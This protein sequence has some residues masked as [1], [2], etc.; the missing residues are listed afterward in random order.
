MAPAA[1]HPPPQH[2]GHGGDPEVA[3]LTPLLRHHQRLLI[4]SQAD[5]L[6]CTG[7]PHGAVAG[8]CGVGQGRSVRSMAPAVWGVLC[9]GQCGNKYP[10]TGVLDG[11][12]YYAAC[13]LCCCAM[14]L[15]ARSL[16]AAA[17]SWCRK[18][19]LGV[20]LP[21]S[22]QHDVRCI[23]AGCSAWPGMPG[24]QHV[25]HLAVHSR[26]QRSRSSCLGASC[27]Y[28]LWAAG[29][30][31]LQERA[32]IIACSMHDITILNLHARHHSPIKQRPVMPIMR[33]TSCMLLAAAAHGW[34]SDRD[35]AN[36]WPAPSFTH[37]THT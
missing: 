16:H 29:N 7:Q 11:P 28:L 15:V 21:R 31:L 30:C 9:Q 2:E 14:R 10:S 23:T 6:C 4:G 33:W 24:M 18:C 27:A 8:G 1:G 32:S 3:L 35:K 26:Q 37:H 22:L 25:M 34:N 36:T 17:A 12:Q 20:A 19:E 13:S 5:L